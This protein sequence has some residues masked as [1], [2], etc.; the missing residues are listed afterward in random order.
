MMVFSKMTVSMGSEAS[1]L[2]KAWNIWNVQKTSVHFFECT[3]IY[4]E[5]GQYALVR[6][7]ISVFCLSVHVYKCVYIYINIHRHTYSQTLITSKGRSPQTEYQSA[8]GH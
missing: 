2:T 4:I 3:L 1:V 8:A 5:Y 6:L 7:S